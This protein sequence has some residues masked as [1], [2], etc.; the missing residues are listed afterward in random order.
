MGKGTRKKE[1][2]CFSHGLISFSFFYSQN[3]INESMHACL[4]A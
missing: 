1:G 4:P 3:R 2:E